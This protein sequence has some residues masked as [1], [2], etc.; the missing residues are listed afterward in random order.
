MLLDTHVILW[1]TSDDRKLSARA[2]RDIARADSIFVS[3]VS[4]L[5]IA[6]LV[7]MERIHLGRD[8]TAWTR[9]LLETDRVSIA[10]LTPVIAAEAGA[11]PN[12]FPRDPADRVLYATARDLAV[13]F[14]T[15]DSPIAEYARRAK[16]V[17]VVW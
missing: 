12:D 16:D 10:A 11:L 5:E 1:W 13:P 6:T 2:R 3:P 7:R 4:C 9:D 8:V 17:R 15:K 14:V